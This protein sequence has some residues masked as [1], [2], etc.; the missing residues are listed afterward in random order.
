MHSLTTYTANTEDVSLISHNLND[1]IILM[2]Y[3]V[4]TR[5]KFD[6]KQTNKNFKLMNLKMVETFATSQ[7]QKYK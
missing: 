6:E 7:L 1:S 3:Q 5:F 4:T 2:P